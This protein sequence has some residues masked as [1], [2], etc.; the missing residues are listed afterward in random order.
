MSSPVRK[1]TCFITRF[2]KAEQELLLFNH[3]N[4]GV[5]IPAGTVNPGEDPLSAARREA[6]EETGLSDLVLERSL[7]KAE[8]PPPPGF[9]LVTHP[10]PVYSRPDIGSYDWAHFRTGLP[11]QVL[12]HEAGFTQV[13]FEETDRYLDPQYSTYIIT[14]WVPD[15]ALSSV[16][17]RHFYLFNAPN[18]TPDR[19][20]VCVDDTIF[21]LFWA[22][23]KDLPSIVPPQDGWIKWL[24]I[25]D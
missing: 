19:W 17:I 23:L 8:D 16:L 14:G 15:D 20:T 5:Q 25:F 10:T 7:G 6:L 3:P 24:P 11:V 13:C 12:R 9:V 22:P 21:E 1:V 2:Q 4:V 18:P